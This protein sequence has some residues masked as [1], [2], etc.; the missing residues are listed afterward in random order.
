MKINFLEISSKLDQLNL[1]EAT[2][3][4]N[5]L[6]EFYDQEYEL[7]EKLKE[8]V[9][10]YNEIDPT[11]LFQ[12]FLYFKDVFSKIV[13]VSDSL[14]E[15]LTAH[16]YENLILSNAES[17]EKRASYTAEDRKVLAKG[18]TSDLDSLVGLAKA[19]LAEAT[20]RMYQYRVTI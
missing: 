13:A 16:W 17:K 4:K 5:Q 14:K 11:I 10:N 1:E 20:S 15:L 19:S 7:F 8:D 18:K 3:I 6:R 12:K 9:D 2:D